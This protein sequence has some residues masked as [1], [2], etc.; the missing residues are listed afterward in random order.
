MFVLL[1]TFIILRCIIV[2]YKECIFECV[3]LKGMAMTEEKA[4]KRN[5]ILL[6]AG[7]ITSKFGVAFYMVVLPLFILKSS[8]DLAWS[9]LFFT[10]STIPAIAATPFLGLIV[11]R[12][13]RKN[14]IV[15]CDLLTSFLYFV[16]LLTY[17]LTTIYSGILLIVTIAI[18]IISNIFEISSKVLFTELVSTETLERYNGIKSFGDNAASLIAP[19][20][21]TIFFGLWGF[22]LVLF[23]MVC[24]YFLSAIQ[25]YFIQ[26]SFCR[27]KRFEKSHWFYDLKDGLHFVCHKKDILNL[28]ILVM[29]LNFFVGGSDEIMNPGI[30]IQKYHI[31]E[32]LYGFT[33]TFLIIGTFLAGLFIFKNKKIKLKDYMHQLVFINSILMIGIGVFSFLFYPMKQLYFC[34]FLIL[35]FFIGFI[36]TC[37]NVPLHSYLQIHTPL[38]YQGRFFALLSFSSNLLVPLGILYS[39]FL[40][41]AVGPDVTYIVNNVFVILIILFLFFKNAQKTNIKST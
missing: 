12:L 27:E 30:I 6:I 22:K 18:N 5:I 26:Y 11:D 32:T 10:L 31:S 8:G 23:I 20:L 41:S 17:D 9:G 37:V 39:G 13:N 16:L 15:A 19:V 24:L 2:S 36:I 29:S 14:I 4:Y 40:S 21:G 1:W 25:E 28:F 33:S 34:T 7:R 35:Q 3:Y 38:E